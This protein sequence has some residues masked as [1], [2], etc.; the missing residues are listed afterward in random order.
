MQLKLVLVLLAWLCYSSSSN[1]TEVIST[2]VYVTDKVPADYT[3]GTFT[4]GSCPTGMTNANLLTGDTHNWGSGGTVQWGACYDTFAITEAINQA[5]SVTGISIDSISYNWKWINGCFNVT[6]EDGT[7]IYCDTEIENRLDSNFKPTGEYA[8]QFDTLVIDVIITDSAGNTVET[9]TYDYD[10]W[11]HWNRQNN[12]STNETIQVDDHGS[13]WQITEDT[14]EL[15]DHTTRTGTIYTPDALGSVTFKATSVDNGNWSGYYGPV[16]QGGDMWFNY[17][18]NPCTL[19][20]A[21]DASCPGYADAYAQNLFDQQ[22]AQ[23]PQYDSSCPGYVQITSQPVSIVE[24]ATSTGNSVVDAVI[25]VPE[26]LIIEPLEI[27]PIVVNIPTIDPIIVETVIIET[28]VNIAEVNL[29]QSLEIEIEAELEAE[30]VQE[31]IIEEIISEEPEEDTTEILEDTQ[32]EED[33]TSEKPKEKGDEDAE[34]NDEKSEENEST[35]DDEEETEGDV[36]SQ[37]ETD[38]DKEEST[39][40]TESSEEVEKPK[41]EVQ[42]KRVLKKSEKNKRMRE[43]VAEKVL[44]ATKELEEATT[45]EQQKKLQETIIALIAFVPDFKDYGVDIDGG[46]VPVLPFYPDVPTVDHGFSRWF[47]NDA[48]FAILE[49]L[50]YN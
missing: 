20:A 27:E 42:K 29:A 43:L 49:D 10:T 14:I 15:Y 45:L 7:K 32:S 5:L 26:P 8:D 16:V 17:R 11:F 28:P 44:E 31:P 2:D 21:Y 38:E 37:E 30:I 35:G 46:N 41:E 3:D 23:N 34:D 22:C 24:Q 4:Y 40:T 19:D 6:K 50:Q 36:E 9:K 48:G 25:A 39:E 33:D 1:A 12:H 18:M 13:V 47:L